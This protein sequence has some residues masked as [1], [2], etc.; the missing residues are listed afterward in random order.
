MLN[1]DQKRAFLAVLLSGVVLF[2]WQYF[3]AAKTN[4]N[5]L[6][7]TVK[8]EIAQTGTNSTSAPALAATLGT[9]TATQTQPLTLTSNTL[10]SFV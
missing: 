9:A 7:T 10:V 8:Q 4:Q 2:G 3:F 1:S 6:T 5:S